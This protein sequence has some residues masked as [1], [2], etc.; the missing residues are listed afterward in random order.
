MICMGSGQ[1]CDLQSQ[2]VV[3]IVVCSGLYVLGLDDTVVIFPDVNLISKSYP[4]SIDT[5]PFAT[6]GTETNA[7]IT[8]V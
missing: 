2:P 7:L 1:S 3:V 8:R 5:S 4:L 6:Y